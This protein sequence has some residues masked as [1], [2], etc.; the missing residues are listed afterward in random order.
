MKLASGGFMFTHHRQHVLT[1]LTYKFPGHFIA[2]CCQKKEIHVFQALRSPQ[3]TQLWTLC[4]GSE[5]SRLGTR[6]WCPN[7]H[8]YSC[9]TWLANL[10]SG[11]V[12]K[13]C[14]SPPLPP[15]RPH[16]CRI[17]T[18]M[19]AHPGLLVPNKSLL[20]QLA[21]KTIPELLEDSWRK[22]WNPN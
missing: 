9:T 3:N 22:G 19:P 6:L 17:P 16:S 18:P 5:C 13:G 21:S 20:W 14:L 7:V 10:C 1:W 2:I 8:I 15:R 11:R 12:W 4:F